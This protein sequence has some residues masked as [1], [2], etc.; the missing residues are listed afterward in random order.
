MLTTAAPRTLNTEDD[1]FTHNAWDHVQPDEEFNS[2]FS[3]QLDL[4]RQHPVPAHL[5]QK[6]QS[7][8]ARYWDVFYKHNTDNFFKDRAWLFLEFP[9][10]RDYTRRDAGPRVLLEMGCGAGNTLT[11]SFRVT[12]SDCDRANGGVWQVVRGTGIFAKA[13]GGGKLTGTY[14][15][16][17]RHGN[18]CEADGLLDHYTGQISR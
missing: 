15:L 18:F 6:F 14:M 9:V 10:L 4:Q 2:F 11:V 17:N 1:P 8:P 5:A 16:G 7:E 13:Q 12:V 3:I